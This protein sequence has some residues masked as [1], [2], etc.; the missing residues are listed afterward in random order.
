MRSAQK[1]PTGQMGY[2]SC[3]P[4]FQKQ[5]TPE[6]DIKGQ[7]HVLITGSTNQEI[8]ALNRKRTE[9]LHIPSVANYWLRH[10]HEMTCL[11]AVTV[12]Q[13]LARERKN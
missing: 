10:C 13:L 3:D 1:H 11:L 5:L 2:A 9:Q 6:N 4:A 12:G 8:G 7:R